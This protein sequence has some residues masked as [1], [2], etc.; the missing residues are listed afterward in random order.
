MLAQNSDNQQ[1][2]SISSKSNQLFKQNNS[3]NKE[4]A[5]A[6]FT[7]KSIN[8]IHIEVLK[9]KINGITQYQKPYISK[10]FYEILVKVLVVCNNFPLVIYVEFI[11][12]KRL[13]LKFFLF[14][15]SFQL[16]LNK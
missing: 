15:F 14:Y 1:Q 12:V 6:S 4:T 3:N 7:N 2:T 10:L 8:E 13:F 5:V 16:L 9:R 11:L